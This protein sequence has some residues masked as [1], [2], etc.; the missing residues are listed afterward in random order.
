MSSRQAGTFTVE[1]LQ[2]IET[3]LRA[4]SRPAA[5]DWFPYNEGDC[6]RQGPFLLE[7]CL[8]SVV[9]KRGREYQA[10]VL[11]DPGTMRTDTGRRYS[12]EQ[13]AYWARVRHLPA[14][15]SHGD[16]G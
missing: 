1:T 15:V 2:N 7:W 6:F 13:G 4:S 16:A 10:G 5:T 11:T 12:V 14:E 8:W 3:D 9:T